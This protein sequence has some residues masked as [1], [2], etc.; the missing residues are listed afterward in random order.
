MWVVVFT[1]EITNE[2]IIHRIKSCQA[3][4]KYIGTKTK[5]EFSNEQG[6]ISCVLR[7]FI[8]I[9][10][11]PLA[12]TVLTDLAWPSL[13]DFSI[14]RH[15]VGLLG[16]GISP[17][18]GLYQNTGQHNTE[19]RRHTSMPRAGFEPVISM[20]QLLLTVHS[21]DRLAIETGPMI[22]LYL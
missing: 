20:F 2:V 17:I 11:F 8:Y 6:E 4:N 1:E 22:Y 15:L 9:Y 10:F 7:N 13:M 21:L 18:Q 16:W 12:S 5:N 19:T 14:H 3:W